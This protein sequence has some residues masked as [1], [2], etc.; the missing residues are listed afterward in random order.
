M[1]YEKIRG[2][3]NCAEIRLIG[4]FVQIFAFFKI[5][6]RVKVSISRIIS[7]QKNLIVMYQNLS[8]PFP[9]KMQFI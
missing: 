3:G 2:N 1:K 5:L 9:D 7:Q 8:L 6:V 4:H